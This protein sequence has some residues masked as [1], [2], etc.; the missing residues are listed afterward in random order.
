MKLKVNASLTLVNKMFEDC[1]NEIDVNVNQL[2]LLKEFNKKYKY[3]FAIM[4]QRKIAEY[5]EKSNI[6]TSFASLND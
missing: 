6:S 2:T 3:R 1:L 5:D 4:T